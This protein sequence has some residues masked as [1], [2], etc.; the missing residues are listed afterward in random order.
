[1]VNTWKNIPKKDI[2]KDIW[3]DFKKQTKPPK[4][5]IS[6]YENINR[7]W[8]LYLAYCSENNTYSVWVVEFFTREI[9]YLETLWTNEKTALRFMKN[10]KDWTIDYFK[11]NWYRFYWDFVID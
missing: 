6:H 2:K 11:V 10:H 3:K 9:K 7:I 4:I 8:N 1:M 5:I